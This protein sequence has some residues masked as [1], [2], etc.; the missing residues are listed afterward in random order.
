MDIES[1]TYPDIQSI[2]TW[3]RDEENHIL[4]HRAITIK[5]R[6]LNKTIHFE[7]KRDGSNFGIYLDAGGNLQCRTRNNI[8]AQ[9][10][11]KR[12]FLALPQATN[13]YRALQDARDCNVDLVIFGE[14]L[15]KGT[16]PARYE[17]HETNDF[18]A[19]DCWNN[20]T[21]RWMPHTEKTTFFA[22]YRIPQVETLATAQFST[23]GEVLEF[24]DSLLATTCL[25]KEGTVGKVYLP[26]GYINFF[27][28]KHERKILEKVRPAGQTGEED[29]REELPDS[30]IWGAV[31][32]AYQE[33]GDQFTNVRYAMPMVARMVAHECEKHGCKVTTK[34][35]FQF[36]KQRAEEKM[37]A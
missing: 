25:E 36:Y 2:A 31:D 10:N 8:Y 27:K 17:K 9:A 26:T 6:I 28:E 19:F 12:G 37:V 4:S 1:I 11:M 23:V 32:K 29:T 34:K 14:Y 22:R 30:E 7:E 21:R 5:E 18:V 16:S 33:L 24:R 3:V 20:V 15:E 35:P 13:V